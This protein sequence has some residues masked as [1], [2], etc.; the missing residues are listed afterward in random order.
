M[1]DRE[2]NH[3]IV[4]VHTVDPYSMGLHAADFQ[5]SHHLAPDLC[6]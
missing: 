5:Q 2:G 4:D 1:W 6:A 3:W